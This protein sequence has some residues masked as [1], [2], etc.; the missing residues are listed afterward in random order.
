MWMHIYIHT[1]RIQESGRSILTLRIHGVLA[2]GSTGKL[3]LLVML[4]CGTVKATPTLL[5]SVLGTQ[6][7]QGRYYVYS[8]AIGMLVLDLN[9]T[10]LGSHP[11]I[12]LKH[13]IMFFI[14]VERHA[15]FMRY[16]VFLGTPCCA[17][18]SLIKMSKTQAQQ[19]V[20][21]YTTATV[22]SHHMPLLTG[23]RRVLQAS[24][25]TMTCMS[26]LCSGLLCTSLGSPISAWNKEGNQC[27][28]R[29][30]VTVRRVKFG[31][32]IHTKSSRNSRTL[33]NRNPSILS[34][35]PYPRA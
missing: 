28:S 2:L 20:C 9:S 25:T 34:S 11:N 6:R 18:V 13:Y 29:I 7:G 3:M 17:A 31:L 14:S 27:I 24:V 26:G 4:S 12:G 10:K 19:T 16:H 1:L 21:A 5:R 22:R 32:C 15:A 30:K 8:N 23:C 33:L 35:S